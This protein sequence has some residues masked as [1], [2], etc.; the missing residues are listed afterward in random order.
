MSGNNLDFPMFN[1]DSRRVDNAGTHSPL[2][3]N[4]STRRRL[5]L[6]CKTSITLAIRSNRATANLDENEDTLKCITQANLLS[7]FLAS[8]NVTY[9]YLKWTKSSSKHLGTNF[10]V[11]T[12][13]AFGQVKTIYQ[14]HRNKF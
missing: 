3:V 13:A 6:R 1:N 7:F 11:Q 14:W 9:W 10:G 4:D 8:S 12:K 5:N 2:V